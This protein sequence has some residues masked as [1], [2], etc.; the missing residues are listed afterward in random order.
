[1]PFF[2]SSSGVQISGGNFYDIAGDI[3][4]QSAQPPGSETELLMPLPL[5]ESVGRLLVGPE[6]H[7]RHTRAAMLVPYNISRHPEIRDRS[8]HPV[9]RQRLIS[10]GPAS[11][12][13]ILDPSTYRMSL[14]SS[15]FYPPSTSGYTNSRNPLANLADLCELYPPARAINE[16]TDHV[17]SNPERRSPLDV[18]PVSTEFGGELEA[19]WSFYGINHPAL[20]WDGHQLKTNINGGTFI[21]G[22]INHIQHGRGEPGLHILHRASASDALH[23]S[24]ERYPQPKCHPETRTK[25]LEDLYKWSKKGSTALLWLYGPAGAGKS[26]IAQSLCHKLESRGR[27]AGSFFF[28]RGHA[29]RGNPLKLFPT[30]AYQL[31]LLLP[32]IRRAIVESMENDPSIVNRSLSVQLQ[33]LIIEP[34]RDSIPSRSLVFIIDGLDE[35]EGQAFQQEILRLF[36]TALQQNQLPF[37]ILVASRQEPHIGEVFREPCLDG[38]HRPMSIDQSFRDVRTYLRKEFSRIHRDHS[39]TMANVLRSWPEKKVIEDLVVKSSGYF[40]YASTVIKFVDDKNFRPTDRLDIIMGIVEPDVE[41]ASP[42]GALDQLYIQILSDVPPMLQLLRILTVVA[43]GLHSD[44]HISKIEQLLELRS[45][46]VRLALR[47]LQSVVQVPVDD[48]DLSLRITVHHASFL[49]FLSN[50]SRSGIFYVTGSQHRTELARQILKA[51]SNTHNDPS[52][53]RN[54]GHVAWELGRT[55]FKIINSAHPSPDLVYLLHSLNPDFLFYQSQSEFGANVDIIRDWLKKAHPLPHDLLQLWLEYRFMRWCDS[56]WIYENVR[57][58]DRSQLSQTLLEILPQASPHLIKILRAH[59]V[60]RHGIAFLAN[61]LKIFHIRLWLDLSWEELRTAL[62][63]LRALDQRGLRELVTSVWDPSLN[64]DLQ[65]SSILRDVDIVSSCLRIVKK[66]DAHEL[67][68][69]FRR[70]TW[71]WSRLLSSCPPCFDLLDQIEL[72]STS[73]YFDRSDFSK[74]L[75]WYE[76]FPPPQ[77]QPSEQMNRFEFRVEEEKDRF[78]KHVETVTQAEEGKLPMSDEVIEQWIREQGR[79]QS[80]K[81]RSDSVRASRGGGKNIFE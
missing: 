12:P 21:G 2:P 6:R 15:S 7:Q 77:P 36:G 14:S 30:L 56:A 33:K 39:E 73:Q 34:C 20:P 28:K 41:Y 18:Q 4:L 32:G 38:F 35:C 51:L 13:L 70:S 44:L 63:Y 26:A 11:L 29:S 54:G 43:A 64:Q 68:W 46:D 24:G 57:E 16:S 9:E 49:D 62:C 17:S 53:N 76:T 22:N 55:A 8:Q 58:V 80:F 1:M 40:V 79:A 25:L 59:K 71:V 72:A 37:R 5:P 47:G 67:P 42:F 3:N 75:Q 45:G 60:A 31:A 50:P 69:Q 27:F 61:E 81:Y 48:E 23:D 74:V 19:P 78:K 66:I 10:A 52:L 65:P